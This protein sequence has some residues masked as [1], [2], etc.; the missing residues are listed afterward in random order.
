MVAAG[1]WPRASGAW[2]ATVAWKDC[3]AVRPPGSV[4]VTVMSAVPR[5][6]ATMVTVLP[7]AE[8]VATAG[9]EVVAEYVRVSPSGSLK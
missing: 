2:L 7:A 6:S 5:A 3:A 4:A 1:T 8:T 9:S